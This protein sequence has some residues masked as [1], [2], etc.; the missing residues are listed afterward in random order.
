MKQELIQLFQLTPSLI[1]TTCAIFL[2]GA[3]VW[4]L[5]NGQYRHI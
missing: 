1:K 2:W 4:L 3:R 5:E